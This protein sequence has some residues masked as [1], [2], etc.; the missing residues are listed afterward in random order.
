[1]VS[2]GK[3]TEGQAMK[4]TITPDE[5]FPQHH[6]EV[7]LFEAGAHVVE[8]YGERMVGSSSFC[9]GTFTSAEAAV[10]AY[11]NDTDED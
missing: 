7:E 4:T 2:N 8:F 6:F 10:E 3:A 9:G 11:R 1:M 5:R